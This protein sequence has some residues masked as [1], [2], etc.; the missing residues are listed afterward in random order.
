MAQRKRRVQRGSSDK[1]TVSEV[2]NKVGVHPATVSRWIRSGDLR[3]TSEKGITVVT[4][5]ALKKFEREFLQVV[6]GHHG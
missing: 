5:A 3:S 1:L 2:A 6:G 4:R